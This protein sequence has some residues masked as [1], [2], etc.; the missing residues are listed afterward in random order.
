MHTP[1][2]M[3]QPKQQSKHMRNE[4]QRPT[5]Q[6]CFKAG[7]EACVQNC[8]AEAAR[9][10]SEKCRALTPQAP[11]HPQA[12]HSGPAGPRVHPLRT[13]TYTP[14]PTVCWCKHGAHALPGR[15]GAITFKGAQE[16]THHYD[17]N[18]L[19]STNSYKYTARTTAAPPRALL[20]NACDV[21]AASWVLL[22]PSTTH[23]PM[24][25]LPAQDPTRNSAPTH[26]TA[27]VQSTADCS[28]GCAARTAPDSLPNRP[29]H[30]C[31]PTALAYLCTCK[32]RPPFSNA[33]ASARGSAARDA[34]AAT[35]AA[36]AAAWQPTFALS[37]STPTVPRQNPTT[38]PP[39][40]PA[41]EETRTCSTIREQLHLRALR[42][43]GRHEGSTAAATLS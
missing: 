22:Q 6:G 20:Y 8:A 30:T 35:L 34:P 19:P 41:A 17:D 23:Q 21:C 1:K 28:T 25:L 37:L 26:R 43:T 9:T 7:G 3:P 42:R 14:S 38:P 27:S 32:L 31:T 2:H 18:K 16:Q 10:G 24:L 40:S 29:Q 33:R 36:T 11:T 13:G 39:N 5:Q 4:G 12:Q 15:L